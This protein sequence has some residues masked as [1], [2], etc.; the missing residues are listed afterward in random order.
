[1]PRA[2]AKVKVEIPEV[3]KIAESAIGLLGLIY[4]DSVDILK[5]YGKSMDARL[6]SQVTAQNIERWAAGTGILRVPLDP[7]V[8][9][10]LA[11]SPFGVPGGSG[12]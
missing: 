9:A 3:A 2:T 8:Q 5:D 11:V 12:K 4:R 1:M 10:P 6:M 7:A